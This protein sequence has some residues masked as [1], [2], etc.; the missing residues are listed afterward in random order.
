VS[1]VI[2]KFRAKYGDNGVSSIQSSTL[3]LSSWRL[4]VR[5][6][7]CQTAEE[8][9][10]RLLAGISNQALKNQPLGKTKNPGVRS[11]NPFARAKS[12]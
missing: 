7:C 3:P 10:A 2:E 9:D 11:S 4:I 6:H 5:H 8:A 12:V 1:S